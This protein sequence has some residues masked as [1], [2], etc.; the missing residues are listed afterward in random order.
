MQD[1]SSFSYHIRTFYI[2]YFALFPIY[3]A[4]FVDK[5]SICIYIL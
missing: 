3:V 2:R 1:F 4:N 5:S